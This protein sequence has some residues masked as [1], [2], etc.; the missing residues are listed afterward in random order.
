LSMNI[1][2]GWLFTLNSL[3]Y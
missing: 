1:K 2:S 3:D